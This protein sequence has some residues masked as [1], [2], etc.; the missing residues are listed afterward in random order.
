MTFDE[1]VARFDAKPIG[2]GY[3]ALCPAHPDKQPSL[4]INRGDNGNGT[5][6]HCQAGCA[7]E[8]VLAAFDLEMRDLFDSSNGNRPTP[9]PSATKPPWDPSRQDCVYV[10]RDET[11]TALYETVRLKAPKDFRA[12]RDVRQRPWSIKDIRH[13]VYRLN[14]LQGQAVIHIAEGEKDADRLWS[15]DLPATTNVGGA[16]KWTDEYTM[17]LYGAG[18]RHV[19]IVPDN[20]DAGRLHAATVAESCDAAG[21]TVQVVTLPEQDIKG[22]DVSDYLQTCPVDDLLQLVKDTPPWVAPTE[23]AP[24]VVPETPT[25]PVPYTFAHAFQ[26][27]HFV[28]RWIE[29]F[30]PQCD[31]SLEYHEAAALVALSCATP[32]L[33]A[34][35]S[36]TAVGLRTNLYVLFI[37]DAGRTRKSTA[38]D[39]VIEALKQSLPKVLLPEQMTPEAFVERLGACSND[40]A[41][42]TID[43]F[44]DYLIK[45]VNATYLAALRGLLLELYGQTDHVY[46]RVSKGAK[47]KKTDDD[48]EGE[49]QEDAFYITN[50]TLSLIGCATPTLFRSLDNTAVGSGLLTRFAII[51]PDSKPKR[52]PQY[53]L[54]EDPVIPAD[55][56]QQLSDIRTWTTDRS[57][58]FAPGVLQRLDEA[59]D[60][61]LDE[62]D[63]RCE[64]T[65]RM[66]VMARKV[67]MLAAAGRP[68]NFE[69]ERT[70]LTVTTEDAES[71]IKVVTRWIGY[72]RAFEVRVNET[73]FEVNVQ[74]CVTVVKGRTVNRRVVA[75]QVHMEAKD[76]KAVEETLIQRD[77]I[78]VK[79]EKP[80]IGRP[81]TWWKWIG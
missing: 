62:S 78:E 16:G 32:S 9:S 10:Y 49:R 48:A 33:M 22:Y 4:S 43:E 71:A 53:E 2:S 21:I 31:A 17:Q 13:V 41:L 20:D 19:I 58:T 68:R 11:G 3:K 12:R 64:M 1:L 14:D 54:T 39:Y 72:A 55:L 57:V 47:K 45:I 44:T 30:S 65:V 34:R 15:V 28:T 76:L 6:I 38:K 52:I 23:V 77:Q 27:G 18:C 63:D 59:I 60:K 24:A 51:Y 80:A 67:A 7:T 5:V 37:G 75:Q 74:R 70:P 73:A 79:V 40:A 25:P 35:I 8:A 42:W 46:A 50:V 56:T 69:L 29:H 36:G 61:P 26:S 81:S 66:G